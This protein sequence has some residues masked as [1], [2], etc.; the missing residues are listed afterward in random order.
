MKP[1]YARVNAIMMTISPHVNST[2]DF[3]INNNFWEEWRR[4]PPPRGRLYYVGRIIDI[5]L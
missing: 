2:L 5:S 3:L 1:D 4:L